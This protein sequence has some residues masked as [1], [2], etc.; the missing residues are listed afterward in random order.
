MQAADILLL[1]EAE[2]DLEEGRQFYD[3]QEA[4]VGDYFWDSLL[5]DIESLIIQAGVH[6]QAYGLHR[7]LAK[8]FPYAVYYQIFDGKAYV[9]A[10]LPVRRSPTWIENRL[11]DRRK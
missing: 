5:A 8:H 1:K 2:E 7:M 10:V 9:V 6:Q 3:E 11:Q 4:G